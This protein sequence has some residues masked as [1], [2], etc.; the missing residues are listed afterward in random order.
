MH[1]G[2]RIGKTEI[3]NEGRHHTLSGDAAAGPGA[4]RGDLGGEPV[5][6][7]APSASACIAAPARGGA[8]EFALRACWPIILAMAACEPPSCARPRVLALSLSSV[9]AF[10]FPIRDIQSSAG[11]QRPHV[12]KRERGFV[13]RQLKLANRTCELLSTVAMH[14]HRVSHEALAYILIKTVFVVVY[15]PA[16]SLV[17]EIIQETYQP[18]GKP[19]Y[20]D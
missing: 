17:H 18:R 13:I 2:T 16:R 5:A 19:V 8:F 1:K 14:F 3:R 9:D 4:T 12:Q 11:S 15:G 20:L 7:A 10:S 6:A